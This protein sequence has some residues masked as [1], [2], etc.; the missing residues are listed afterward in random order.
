LDLV[1]ERLDIHVA[2]EGQDRRVVPGLRRDQVERQGP[3]YSMLARVV[4]K[5]VL[6]GTMLPSSTVTVKRIRSAARPWWV[7]MISE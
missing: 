2:L 4:S 1:A 3:W 7:G 6:L 5:C